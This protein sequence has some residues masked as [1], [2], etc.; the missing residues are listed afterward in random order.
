MTKLKLDLKSR[1]VRKKR[2]RTFK[3][4]FILIFFAV[5]GFI[6]SSLVYNV[7]VRL[8]LNSHQPVDGI[9]VLGGSI[10]R[11]MYAAQLARQDPDIP[12]IISQGSK[13]P[14]VKLIFEREQASME[15]V[16]LEQC[17]HSTFENFF[18]CVPLL[19]QRGFNKVKL[20]TSES[21]LPRAKWLAQIHLGAKG[22]AVEVDTAKEIGVP[23]NNESSLKTF[24]DVT[25]SLIWAVFSQIIQPPCLSVTPLKEVN[26]SDWYAQGFDCERQGGL[27]R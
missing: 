4:L 14:C 25:R 15:Q 10:R 23:G 3:R 5:I 19:H 2:K 8:P 27:N 22:I 11:E 13:A 12:I 9:L 6:F 26:L 1:L 21:H 20:I 16:L 7:G 18:F 17:A 24:L